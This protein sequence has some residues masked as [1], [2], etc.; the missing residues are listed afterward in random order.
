MPTF[1]KQYGIERTGTNVVRA[2]LQGYVGGVVVLMHVLGD[3]HSPPVDL[4]AVLSAVEG[5]PD[6]ALAFVATATQAAPALTTD[7]PGDPRQVEHLRTLARDL[8]RAALEDDIRVAV[9]IREPYDWARSMLVYQGWVRPSGAVADPEGLAPVVSS[10]CERFNSSYSAWLALVDTAPG[11]GAVVRHE[12]LRGDL[13][14]LLERLAR[15][16]RLG[17]PLRAGARLPHVLDASRWDHEEAPVMDAGFEEVMEARRQLVPPLPPRLV[18]VVTDGIDWE[19]VAPYGYA[20]L[21]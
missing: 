5:R 8:H 18:E 11:R 3:K 15:T 1:V 16:L 19:L 6:A 17:K 21:P 10:L 2:L 9:S 14:P 13:D 4:R 20:P 12:D 7:V